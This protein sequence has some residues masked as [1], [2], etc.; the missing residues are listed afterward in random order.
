MISLVVALVLSQPS[1][2]DLPK[3]GDII[4]KVL[5]KCYAMKSGQGE[6]TMTQT[7]AAADKSATTSVSTKFAFERP[8]RLFLQQVSPKIE[9]KNWLVKCDG[10][11]FSYDTPDYI[12]DM[13]GPRGR[14]LEPVTVRGKM[15]EL[16]DIFLAAKRSLGDATNPFLEIMLASKGHDTSLK[17]FIMRIKKHETKSLRKLSDGS[18]VYVISGI[19]QFGYDAEIEAKFGI[20]QTDEILAPTRFELQVTKEYDLKRVEFVDSYSVTKEGQNTPMTVVVNTVWKSTIESDKQI[21][22]SLFSLSSSE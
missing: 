18:E 17:A 11:N 4:S 7:G 1:A 21:D 10:T 3:S 19:I 20:K 2:Q 16:G 14:L 5:E 6:I 12:G 8:N 15:L 9:P 22:Q 13:H